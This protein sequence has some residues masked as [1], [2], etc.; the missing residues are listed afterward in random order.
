MFK[1]IIFLLGLITSVYA[2]EGFGWNIDPSTK[3]KVVAKVGDVEITEMEVQRMMKILLP[4]NFYHRNITEEKLKEIREKAIQNLIYRE[5]LYYEAKKK[6]LKVTEKEINNLMDQLIKQY[7]SKENLEKL[8]KQTGLTIEGFKKELEKRLLVDKLIKKYAIVSLTDK[9]LK[10]YYEKNKDKFK[11]P[12]SVKVRYIYIKVDPS[13]PKGREKAR[14]KAKKAYKEIKEGKDFG[15]VA[16][17]Y[18]DDLS[19][20][21]GGDIGY[22]HKGR[23]PKQIEEEIYKLDVGQVSKIIETDTGLHIVKIEDKRPPRLVPYEEIKDKLKKELTEVMQERKFN[24]LIKDAKKN[25][26]VEIYEDKKDS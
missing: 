7:K 6:G 2:Y 21:K 12:A 5:L 10:E 15:D 19:R 18:S 3:N 23:F 9:D 26:K 16:Y 20:I 1:V 4:M 14:E 24:E 13:D 25:L 17:R 22:V 11:E 8:L